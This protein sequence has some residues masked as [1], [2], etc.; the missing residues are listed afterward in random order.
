M[1]L[2]DL[3]LFA[4]ISVVIIMFAV[5]AILLTVQHLGARAATTT[6]LRTWDRVAHRLEPA[7][8]VL[9]A[10]LFGLGAW[11]VHLSSGRFR[12]SDGWVLTAVVTLALMELIGALLLAPRGRRHSRLIALAEDGRPRSGFA[13][14][15]ATR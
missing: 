4:H 13:T 1:K 3:V 12:W 2:F 11:L 10:L 6:E 5:A 15:P 8:P 9:A 7:L 14:Q